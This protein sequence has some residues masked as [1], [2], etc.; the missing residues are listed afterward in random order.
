MVQWSLQSR[1]QQHHHHQNVH[2][3]LINHRSSPKDDNDNIDKMRRS[4]CCCGHLLQPTITLIMLH[5]S[6]F[7]YSEIVKTS[8]N[9][10]QCRRS[11][12]DDDI[13]IMYMAG[14]AFLLT[15]HSFG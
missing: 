12:V 3:A 1:E 9:I 14:T 10:L 11:P 15:I 5:T 7:S 4:T 6:L 13:M 2:D 8:L